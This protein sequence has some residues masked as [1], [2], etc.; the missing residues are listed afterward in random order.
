ML[1][2]LSPILLPLA[3]VLVAETW[4]RLAGVP[5]YL[6][7]PP[8]AVAGRLLSDPVF[9]AGHA[10]RTLLGAL[11]G[12]GLGVGVALPLGAAMAHSP[13]LERTLLPLAILTKVTPVVALAPLF[14]IWFGFGW[15]P[16]VLIVA[17][18]TFFP[19]LVG[20]IA[21]L[22]S[23]D[24]GALAFL[25]SVAASPAEVFWKLRAP[26][27]LPHLFAALRVALPLALIGAVVAEWLGSDR[28]LGH[29]VGAAHT[30]LDLPTLAAAVVVLATL[31][32]FLTALLARAERRALFWQP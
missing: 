5:V 30:R 19:V 21:G 13:G 16:T 3:L 11:L 1:K 17:L 23:V 2:R 9:F 32:A 25:G 18:F 15:A 26:S 29:V 6:V 31:G 7:P 22:R 27:A 8:S 20:A 10:A 12:L 28:G 14:V 24:A 4:V